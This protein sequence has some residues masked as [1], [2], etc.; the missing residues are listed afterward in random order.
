MK[1]TIYMYTCLLAQLCLAQH[2]VPATATIVVRDDMGLPVNCVSLNGG[3]RDVSNA[4]SRDRFT[5]MTDTNG[6]FIA[7]GHALIGV[8]VRATAEGYYE[9]I[10]SVPLDIKQGMQMDHWGVTVPVV[11][12]RIRNP[13]PM[14]AKR[15]A[16][17]S[18][19]PFERVGQYSLGRTSCYDLVRGAFLPPVGIS[20]QADLQ[21]TWKMTIDATNGVGRAL[22]YDCLSEIRMT[23]VE[24]GIC[25]GNPDGGRGESRDEGSAYFS[26]Y[27]A[28]MQG[29]TNT[30]SFYRNVHGEKAE[31]NDEQHY[32][33]YF[34]IRTQTNEMGQVTNALYGKIYGQINGNFTYYLN[35]TPNDRNMEFDPKR[36]LFTHLKPLE[37]VNRP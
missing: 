27:Q 5:G 3:F 29:Y 16:N 33:Y 23:N 15:V 18:F 37:L 20:K 2:Y 28:P 19:D 22:E 24:D 9:T 1:R 10:T 35:P 34:R 31:S 36:N 12:K 11:L 32:L 13:I 7:K 25:K 30:I 8:G 17:H 6:A 21:F 14:Y 26:A 4:G